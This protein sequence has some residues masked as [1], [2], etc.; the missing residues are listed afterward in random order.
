M[1]YRTEVA[2]LDRAPVVVNELEAWRALA[3]ERGRQLEELRRRLLAAIDSIPDEH[4]RALVVSL[5]L[6]RPQWLRDIDAS[7]VNKD[8]ERGDIENILEDLWRRVAADT[9]A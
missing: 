5:D 8:L 6:T 4:L 9:P 2:G 3:I 7:S 1:A